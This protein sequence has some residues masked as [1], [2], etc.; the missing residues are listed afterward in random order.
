MLQLSFIDVPGHAR[1]VRNMLA[2]AGGIDAVLLTI[3]AND[4][5]MPQTRE[6]LA[7]CSLLGI[8]RGIVVLTKSDTVN[9]AQLIETTRLVGDF[10]SGTFLASAPVIPVSAHSGHNIAELGRAMVGMA[11]A[12]PDRNTDTL[13]RLPIDRAF[14]IKGFGTVVT[15]TL[16]GG[17]VRSGD[18]LEI[19]PTGRIVRVRGM[20]VHGRA[21]E[22]ALAGSR[23]ALNLAHVDV[24]EI[25]RGNTCVSPGSA[26]AVV[27][28][29]VQLSLLPS[30]QTL[31]HRSRLHFHAFASECLATVTLYG[32]PSLEPGDTGLA[33]L[34]LSKP[35]VLLPGDRFVLRSGTPVATI[36]GG[37][38]LDAHPQPHAK[39]AMTTTWLRE[40]ASAP[41]EE[42]VWLFVAKAGRSGDFSIRAFE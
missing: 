29:D 18:D 12:I 26:Q 24:A 5:V 38:V 17:K 4:G 32:A 35:V 41:P 8:Q 22:E 10:L 30:E 20:E 15:G 34:R 21:Q 31:K 40:L 42:S 16:I 9:E 2:G 7:I 28:V 19:A 11:S 1:F 13:V 14:V 25:E 27:T 37:R 6:H 33:R 23:V 3:A 39:K 36:G